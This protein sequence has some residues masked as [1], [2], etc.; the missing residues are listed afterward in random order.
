MLGCRFSFEAYVKNVRQA[1]KCSAKTTELV[2]D[3][4]GH[5]ID[6]YQGAA[7]SNCFRS[8]ANS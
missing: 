4:D 6:I 3:A 8:H 7:A 5:F 2:L 1:D